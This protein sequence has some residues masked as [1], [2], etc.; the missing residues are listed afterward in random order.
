MSEVPL[1]QSMG[2]DAYNVVEAKGLDENQRL[3]L[4]LRDTDH[5]SPQAGSY[6]RG[7]R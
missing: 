6:R 7:V 5:A 4:A 2:D 1:R 3:S